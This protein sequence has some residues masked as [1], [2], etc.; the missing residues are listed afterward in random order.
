ML[1][2]D[3][4][5]QAALKRLAFPAE[6][7]ECIWRVSDTLLVSLPERTSPNV[8]I[9]FFSGMIISIF[10]LGA[11]LRPPSWQHPLQR[12][13]K[14]GNRGDGHLCSVHSLSVILMI[15]IINQG[16]QQL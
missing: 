16:F 15:I 3:F 9:F 8:T 10:S 11:G 5:L 7:Q 4:V 14:R 2:C 1:T 6:A 12:A 13:G